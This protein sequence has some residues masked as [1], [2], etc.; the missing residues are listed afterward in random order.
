M[1]NSIEAVMAMCVVTD[2]IIDDTGISSQ[3]GTSIILYSHRLVF[4]E[5]E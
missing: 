1:V 3:F 5:V 2:E 4:E